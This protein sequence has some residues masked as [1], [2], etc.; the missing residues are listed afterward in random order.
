MSD[1]EEDQQ[2][3]AERREKQTYLRKEI[4]DFGFEPSAFQDFLDTIKPDGTH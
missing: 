4:L 3:I 1:S 2:T